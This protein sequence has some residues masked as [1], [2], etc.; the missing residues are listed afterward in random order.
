MSKNS[1]KALI[2]E[3]YKGRGNCWIKIDKDTSTYHDIYNKIKDIELAK[4]YINDI[5]SAGFAWIRFV[6]PNG[7]Q[8]NPQITCEI[9]YSGSKKE[10]PDCTID[11][12]DKVAINFELLGNTPFKLELE[13][14]HIKEKKVP[15]VVK[16]KIRKEKKEKFVNEAQKF[17][18]SIEEIVEN[19]LINIKE[20]ILQQP[21]TTDLIQW[22]SFLEAEGLLK[23][24]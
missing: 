22:K 6:S 24:A 5:E 2:R 9:R 11:I 1:F 15:K 20:A 21:T 7:T 10:Q 4:D 13:K 3:R 14:K 23:N 12:D 19:E 18:E 8:E 17:Q 16:K